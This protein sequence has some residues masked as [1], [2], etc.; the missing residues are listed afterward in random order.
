VK[1]AKWML[2]LTFDTANPGTEDRSLEQHTPPWRKET[3][4]WCKAGYIQ[5]REILMGYQ[6]ESCHS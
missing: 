6:E 2:Q 1:T 5:A 3:C 4:W